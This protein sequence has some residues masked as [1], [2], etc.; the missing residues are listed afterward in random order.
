[1]SAC[2]RLSRRPATWA[3]ARLS[4]ASCHGGC[5]M[6][7]AHG[8]PSTNRRSDGFLAAIV[9]AAYTGFSPVFVSFSLQQ[10][11]PRSICYEVVFIYLSV[12]CRSGKLQLSEL[13]GDD[14]DSTGAAQAISARCDHCLS[15]SLIVD[16]ASSLTCKCHRQSAS[17]GNVVNSCAAGA[18]R[19]CLS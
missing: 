15:V 8:S 10:E 2:R 3:L 6:P 5:A 11:R 4:S 17:S 1:M 18:E 7:A 19:R 16:A 9:A 14:S 12:K 13:L